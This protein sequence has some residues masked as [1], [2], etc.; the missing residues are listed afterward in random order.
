QI[1]DG[2]GGVASGAAAL[3]DA[4]SEE[5]AL[6]NQ[7]MGN[8]EEIASRVADS[9]KSAVYAKNQ[10][11]D[12]ASIVKESSDKMDELLNSMLDIATSAEKIVKIN[13]TIEDIAFQTN[14]LALNASVEAARAGE[15]GKGFAVVADEVRNLASKFADASNSTNKL[16]AETV[17]V[18]ESGKALAQQTADLLSAVVERTSVIETGVTEISDVTEKQRAQLADIVNKLGEVSGV[19]ETTAS[20][21]EESAAASEQLDEQVERLKDSLKK[22]RI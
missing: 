12:T 21:A 16:I 9:A 6:I 19:V 22:Y 13:S 7:V 11:R 10:T 18:I 2:S 5:T 14:I 20:T 1:S 17:S 4:V 3:A 8:V 15:A